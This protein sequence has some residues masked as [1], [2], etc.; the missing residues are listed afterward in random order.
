MTDA[1]EKV[2]G[3]SQ[4]LRYSDVGMEV[5]IACRFS[6]REEVTK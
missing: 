1:W 2:H 3:R 5:A 6:K 4:G